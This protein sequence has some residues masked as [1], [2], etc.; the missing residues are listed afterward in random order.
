MN[1]SNY[2]ILSQLRYNVITKMRTFVD[3][4]NERCFPDYELSQLSDY[5]SG[6]TKKIKKKKLNEIPKPLKRIK[7]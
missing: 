4:N 7:K 5:G 1:D 3:I 2:Q 6:S